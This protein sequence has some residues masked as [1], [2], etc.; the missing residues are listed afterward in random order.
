MIHI[1][2]DITRF[3]PRNSLRQFGFL[4]LRELIDSSFDEGLERRSQFDRSSEVALGF[5]SFAQLQT[6]KTAI[7]VSLGVARIDFDR[8]IEIGKGGLDVSF[9]EFRNPAI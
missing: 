1:N 6:D 9:L 8:L 4:L 7:D 2:N 3:C 5:G